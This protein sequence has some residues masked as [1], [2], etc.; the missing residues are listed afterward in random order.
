MAVKKRVKSK[1]TKKNVDVEALIE[2][3]GTVPDEAPKEEFKKF[4]MRVPAK[5]LAQV[6]E[7][8]KRRRIIRYRNQWVLEAI[9]EKLER[10]AAE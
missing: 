5:T 4:L 8:V 1:E 2:R 3:G 9:Y 10:E 6:D 7:A